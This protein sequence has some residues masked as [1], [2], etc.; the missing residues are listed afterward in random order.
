MNRYLDILVVCHLVVYNSLS[1]NL[2][3]GLNTVHLFLLYNFS[4]FQACGW[5][6]FPAFFF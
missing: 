5:R 1:V 4:L 3:E 6:I 2:L